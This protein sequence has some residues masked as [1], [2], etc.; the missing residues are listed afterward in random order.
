VKGGAKTNSP[1]SVP[2]VAKVWEDGLG[3]GGGIKGGV[4]FVKKGS[5][6]KGKKGKGGGPP[7]LREC[8]EGKDLNVF[9]KKKKVSKKIQEK[10]KSGGAEGKGLTRKIRS[11]LRSLK[12]AGSK[13]AY[14]QLWVNYPKSGDPYKK[15]NTFGEFEWEVPLN[16]LAKEAP[17][18]L[19]EPVFLAWRAGG[20]KKPWDVENRGN[21]ITGEKFCEGKNCRKGKNRSLRK[22][23]KKDEKELAE[24]PRSCWNNGNKTCMREREGNQRRESGNPPKKN[25]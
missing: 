21:Q 10:R 3:R 18:A 16:S 13:S 2:N 5:V 1:R 25:I 9:L 22:K 8:R 17:R 4:S 11:F 14:D 19:T 20:T 23:K 12:K 6:Q 15:K 24:L 7:V